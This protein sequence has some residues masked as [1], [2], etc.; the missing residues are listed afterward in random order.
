MEGMDTITAPAPWALMG[1]GYIIAVKMAPDF[2]NEKGFVPKTLEGCFKGG[3]GTIMYVD[4]HYSD[5]GPYQEL[6]FIPGKFDFGA[7]KYFSI[8]KIFV[9]TRDSVQNGQTNWGI[10]KEI[11]TFETTRQ[12]KNTE[13]IRVMKDGTVCTDLTLRSL[14]IRIPVT[15]AL[16]PAFL[17][18][19]AQHHLGKT[20]LTTLKAR[21]TIKPACLKDS[22][23]NGA[24]FPDFTRGRVISA[25]EVP[26]FFMVFP[27]ARIPL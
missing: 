26:G 5:V 7:G 21:G 25:F 20:Y 6:L 2:V 16:V 1:R 4:Y 15:T 23:I 14:P 3:L 18:T 8:T 19:L 9:S 17:R 12:S 11:A 24:F 22:R 10:P 13:H 27:R